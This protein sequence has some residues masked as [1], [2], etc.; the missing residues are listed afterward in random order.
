MINTDKIVLEVNYNTLLCYITDKDGV[1]KSDF[2]KFKEK[3]ELK[4]NKMMYEYNQTKRRK[5]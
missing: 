3:L 5:I 1:F 4:L 2:K